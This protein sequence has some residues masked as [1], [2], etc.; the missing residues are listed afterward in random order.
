MNQ[1]LSVLA[2]SPVF[3]GRHILLLLGLVCFV[4]GGRV[5]QRRLTS[6]VRKDNID[7]E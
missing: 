7:H 2:W 4:A 6:G 1:P 5:L 3:S